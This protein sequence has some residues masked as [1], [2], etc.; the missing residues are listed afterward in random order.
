MPLF[1]HYIT[2]FTALV[3]LF[4]SLSAPAGEVLQFFDKHAV[5]MLLID[6]ESGQIVRANQAASE[7][8]GYSKLRLHEMQIQ[9]INALSPAAVAAE[10]SL[11]EKENRNYFIFRHRLA[12]GSLRTVQVSSVPILLDDTPLLFS[13]VTDINDLRAVQDNLWHYQ[14]RLE[15]MVDQQVA[16]LRSK[17]RFIHRLMIIAIASLILTALTL[18]YLLYRRQRTPTPHKK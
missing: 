3:L 5:A 13:I 7:Y 2:G 14:N 8:Y 1:K 18:G 12:D 11:A 4:F 15:E 9:Q 16:H 10:R 17:D 6:P